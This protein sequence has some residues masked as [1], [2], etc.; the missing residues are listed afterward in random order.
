[1]DASP[2]GG[3]KKA[4]KNRDKANKKSLDEKLKSVQDKSAKMRGTPEA[5]EKL[6]KLEAREKRLRAKMAGAAEKKA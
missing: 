1:M 6:P 2:A 4:G 3:K 5:A